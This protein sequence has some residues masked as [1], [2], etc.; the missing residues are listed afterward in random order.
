LKLADT[1]HSSGH[2]YIVCSN[3]TPQEEVAL[4]N[5]TTKRTMSDLN[6]VVQPGEHPFVTVETVV[7]YGSGRLFTQKQ[8]DAA[9]AL[10]AVQYPAVSDELLWRIQQGAL[11]SDQ[12]PQILQDLVRS[13]LI[14]NPKPSPPF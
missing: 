7:E 5:F 10:W 14:R 3:P 13:S 6:C 2:L 1:I 9:I 12:T 4:F 11:T 8:W